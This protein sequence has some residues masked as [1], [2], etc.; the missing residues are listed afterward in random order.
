MAVL[1]EAIEVDAE[2]AAVAA[3]ATVIALEAITTVVEVVPVQG[4]AHLTMIDIT[5]RAVDAL[6]ETTVMMTDT[7]AG[8][9]TEDVAEAAAT[10]VR[11]RK[12]S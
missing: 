3:T 2:A 10:A 11:H 12:K 9:A 4:H 5:V 1:T 8:N 7:P 6:D